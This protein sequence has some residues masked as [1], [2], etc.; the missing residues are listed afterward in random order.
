MALVL[1]SQDELTRAEKVLEEALA[2]TQRIGYGPGYNWARCQMAEVLLDAGRAVEAEAIAR[3]AVEGFIDIFGGEGN[4]YAPFVLAR[5]LLAQ[6]K[7]SAAE[8][9]SDK[10]LKLMMKRQRGE[11]RDR[12]IRLRASVIHAQARA[13]SGREDA[14]SSLDTVLKQPSKRGLLTSSWRRDWP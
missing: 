4:E 14:W 9:T 1:A 3:K 13:A 7:V 5:S 8:D 12:E 6:G 2:L 10:V 11:I